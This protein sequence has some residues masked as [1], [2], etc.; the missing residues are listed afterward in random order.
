MAKN[1]KEIVGLRFGKLTVTRFTG[2]RQGT[3]SIFECQCDC[4]NTTNV[5]RQHLLSGHTKSCG[6]LQSES[7][8]ERNTKHGKSSDR[9]AAIWYGMRKRC[10][11]KTA[12]TFKNYGGRGITMCD[13][14]KND[15]SAFYSWAMKNGYAENLTI[16]RIDVNGDYCPENCRWITNEEQ[17]NNRRTSRYVTFG[18]ETRTVKDWAEITGIKYKTLI[19][20]LN[21]GK[22]NVEQALTTTVKEKNYG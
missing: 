7:A 17:Q 6:C 3:Q 11:C 18:G 5:R 12:S 16:D 9:I 10:F 19:G 8:K 21:N 15:F 13:D 2:K 4:G 1:P 14:W 22:W 20:R